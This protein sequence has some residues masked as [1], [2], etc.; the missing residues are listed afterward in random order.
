MRC[1][2]KQTQQLQQPPPPQQQRQQQPPPP[3]QPLTSSSYSPS[4]VLLTGDKDFMP[5]MTRTRQK[6]KRVALATMRANC[7]RDLL[8]PQVRS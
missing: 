2:N 3:P 7:N 4:Q 8:Q 1:V 5:V 6:G